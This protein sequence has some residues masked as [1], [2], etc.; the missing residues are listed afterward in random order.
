MKRKVNHFM[1]RSNLWQ[2]STRWFANLLSADCEYVL[3]LFIHFYISLIQLCGSLLSHT[4]LYSFSMVINNMYR[5][6]HLSIVSHL[7]GEPACHSITFLNEI[8]HLFVLERWFCWMARKACK[9]QQ[10]HNFSYVLFY[11]LQMCLQ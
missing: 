5:I 6:N 2:D 11:L 10:D 3:N 1:R 4:F 9:A 8:Y 7:K